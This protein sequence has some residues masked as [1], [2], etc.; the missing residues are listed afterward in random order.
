MKRANKYTL[1]IA[2][3]LVVAML[4]ACVPPAPVQPAPLDEQVAGAGVN[5]LVVTA[6]TVRNDATV[7]G[8]LDI[9]GAT[10]VDGALTVAGA[11]AG[12]ITGDITIDDWLDITAQTAISVT[13]GAI[14]TPTGS[15]QPLTSGG[16]VTTSTTTPIAAGTVVGRVV[17]LR[18]AN[19]SD[20]IT[21]DGTGGTVECKANVVMGAGDTLTLF[22]TG[23]K[24]NCLSSY[25]N[26]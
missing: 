26:S 11:V 1:F 22:W 3:L 15:Y 6:L 23:A 10:T 18:N 25:D 7:N 19:A 16:A 8:D 9:G 4:A 17:I 21:I 2:I 14:I 12:D 5:E 24:W 20:A 13:A